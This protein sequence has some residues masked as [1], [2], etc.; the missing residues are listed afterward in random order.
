MLRTSNCRARRGT[1]LYEM[2][3]EYHRPA[4][5]IRVNING[6][7]AQPPGIDWLPVY[8]GWIITQRHAPEA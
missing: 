2:N 4:R 7:I 5:L 3:M 8:V 6:Q 1:I